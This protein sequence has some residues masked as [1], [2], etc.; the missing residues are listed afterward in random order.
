MS[1]DLIMALLLFLM[2][3]ERTAYTIG[4]MGW[5]DT[6]QNTRINYFL[7]NLGFALG[8]LIYLYVRTTITPP[9]KLTRIDFYHFIPVLLFITYRLWIFV[10]DYGR[11]DWGIGYEGYWQRE[12]HLVY[13][14]PI[15]RLLVYTSQ[16][17]YYAFTIQLVLQYRNTITQYFSNIEK[18][19]LNWIRDFMILYTF[20]FVYGYIT[21][22]IDA[23]IVGLDYVHNWWVHFF[24]AIAIVYLGIRAY[25]TDLGMLQRI[26][27]GIK[28]VQPSVIGETT[29]V[30]PKASRLKI[31]M[32]EGQHFLD[33]NLTLLD[34]S[35][36][37]GWTIH[38]V[39]DT[40][41][42]GFDKNFN[43]WVNDYRVDALKVKLLD[44]SYDHF[45]LIALAFD[46]GFNSKATFNRVFKQKTGLSPSQFKAT[47]PN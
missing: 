5:Y 46:C 11:E 10:M 23:F 12:F 4:F 18:V 40:I 32:E 33:P 41:N 36:S 7:I 39:S 43:D 42:Q 3:Y 34:L 1:A 47:R 2:A 27:A 24:S 19:R 30:D 31:L 22:L 45:S 44:S 35:K 38:E 15:Y 9:F 28:S 37:I 26:T 21:D 14:S 16:V 29:K 13:V 20:L 6:F 8:P 17:I 25:F